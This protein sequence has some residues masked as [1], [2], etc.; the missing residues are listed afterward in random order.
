MIAKEKK[1]AIIA[2]T[3]STSDAAVMEKLSTEDIAALLS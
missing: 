2:A 1:Q 3:V